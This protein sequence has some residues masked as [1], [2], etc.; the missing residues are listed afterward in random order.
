MRLAAVEGITPVTLAS[1][2]RTA[3]ELTALMLATRGQEACHDP[4]VA[5]SAQEAADLAHSSG[6]GL[7]ATITHP[8]ADPAVLTALLTT[9]DAPTASSTAAD[10]CA[11]LGQ[12]DI[13]D[14]TESQTERGY[15]VVVVERITASPGCQ[16]QA[17]VL[18]PGT[19]RVAVF[20]L[21]SATGRG[22]WELAGLLGQLV[23]SL[24]FT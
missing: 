4:G 7:V 22:W 17:V 1:P 13:A 9:T 19:R 20:T 5:Q 10:L 12:D 24:E 21:H 8:A 14:V 23:T 11:H 15:P 3:A 18:D 2:E 6:A 16:L